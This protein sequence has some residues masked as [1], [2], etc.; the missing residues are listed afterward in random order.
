[1][2]ATVDIVHMHNTV[3]M[4]NPSLSI[5]IIYILFSCL[6]NIIIH[7]CPLIVIA[8]MASAVVPVKVMDGQILTTLM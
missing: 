1:M 5:I 3:A 2:L 6:Y 8:F 4:Y 7:V